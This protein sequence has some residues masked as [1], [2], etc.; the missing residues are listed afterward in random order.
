MV[1]QTQPGP[2]LSILV[3][4]ILA[5]EDQELADIL[6]I[7][8]SRRHEEGADLEAVPDG[9]EHSLREPRLVE[10]HFNRFVGVA[11]GALLPAEGVEARHLH[12]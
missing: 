10:N 8:A 12:G 3:L 9:A 11:P 1:V 7:R 6:L 2:L 5:D 4:E